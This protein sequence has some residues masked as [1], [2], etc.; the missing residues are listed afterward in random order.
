[1]TSTTTRP[2]IT[3]TL[4]LLF[5]GSFQISKACDRSSIQ[6][7]SLVIEEDGSYSIY[8]TQNIGAGVL[9][10]VRGADGNTSTFAY[11]FYG[12]SGTLSCNS[13]PGSL[14]ADF[15]GTTNIGTD[16]NGVLGAQEVIA[17]ISPGAPYACVNSTAQCGT[18]HTDVKQLFFSFNEMPD[19]IRLMG[20]EGNGNPFLGCRDS[21]MFIDFS[22]L[23]VVW[24][25]FYGR[26]MDLEIEL[27]WATSQEVNT[28]FFEVLRSEDGFNFDQ[29]GTVSAKGIS[30]AQQNYKFMDQHPMNGSAYYQI[31]QYD[32]DGRSTSTEVI[33]IDFTL[34]AQLAW[35]QVGPNPV[36]DH[37][38]IGFTSPEASSY[39]LQVFDLKG[40]LIQQTQIQALAGNNT[41]DLDLSGA[42]SGMYIIRLSSANDRLDKKI[43]KL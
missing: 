18:V 36:T 40:Q 28:D 10:S 6:M 42:A 3:L 22:I 24:N 19:S 23:P 25:G 13:F 2:T 11:G 39:Q 8:L 33:E 29:I 16:M 38:G 1:M 14:T 43:L 32:L 20:A 31:V 35:T 4:L 9:G 12:S 30:S 17:Y 41:H 26:S 27:N 34:N 37:A 21:D 7:D 5:L 15:T